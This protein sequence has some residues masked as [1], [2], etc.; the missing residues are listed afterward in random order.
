MGEVS[1]FC[2]RKDVKTVTRLKIDTHDNRGIYEKKK[3]QIVVSFLEKPNN[4]Y[5]HVQSL[6]EQQ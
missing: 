5:I 6:N 2:Q 1:G 4:M 3:S